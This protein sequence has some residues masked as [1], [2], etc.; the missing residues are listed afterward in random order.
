MK[1]VY[2]YY[3]ND[4]IA[5]MLKLKIIVVG[6]L[7]GF[8][9]SASAVNLL[10]NGSFENQIPVTNKPASWATTLDGT[11]WQG[12]TKTGATNTT[13]KTNTFAGV[14]GDYY[15]RRYLFANTAAST[16]SFASISYNLSNLGLPA[17]ATNLVLSLYSTAT[18]GATD[19]GKLA[20]Y[21]SLV[22]YSGTNG[23]GSVLGTYETSRLLSSTATAWVQLSVTSAIP[24]SALSFSV[25]GKITTTQ[26]LAFDFTGARFDGFDITAVPKSLGGSG[27]L[28]VVP[29][30]APLAAAPLGL[31]LNDAALRNGIME[32][33]ANG[34]ELPDAN[35]CA[36]PDI[37]IL[38]ETNMGD[39]YRIHISY[40][41]EN[42][43]KAYAYLLLPNPKPTASYPKPLVICA[44]PTGYLGKDI[45]CSVR[46]VHPLGS[47][48]NESYWSQRTYGLDL[49]RRGFIVFAP[50][51]AGYGER[52]DPNIPIDFYNTQQVATFTTN[53]NAKWPNVRYTYKQVWDIQR[54]L[55][56]LTTYAGVDT[57]NI[58]IIGHSLGGTAVQS[59]MALDPR[60]KAGVANAGMT[61]HYQSNLWPATGE[62]AL[63]T[64]LDN[65]AAQDLHN[66]QNIFIMAT[67]P[68]ALMVIKP[69][70]DADTYS[71]DVPS[72]TE[73][74]RAVVEYY[75]TKSGLS[76]FDKVPF[77]LYMHVQKHSFEKESRA[78]AYAWLEKQ[79]MPDPNDP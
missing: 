39:H 63:Q 78:L 37:Q 3:A 5:R 50:D 4:Y 49:V 35:D 34:G 75:Q 60:I 58:G 23:T 43:D 26:T 40:M 67:A 53:W 15:I 72:E 17:G 66:M 64:F 13:F 31:R 69:L 9:L 41:V 47:A 14:E 62:P 27:F 32:Y 55:D 73:A 74:Y 48:T 38:S 30:A 36:A 70:N 65:K 79:L 7:G 59:T 2:K 57:N 76:K 68:R 42:D 61:I 1:I 29:A 52:I 33:F 45:A 21:G 12:Y 25:N 8:V 19:A 28:F 56:F 24:A 54:A 44:Q 71:R 18:S 77:G 16:W 46:P 51:T 20:T 22:F 10:T 6:L 11:Y